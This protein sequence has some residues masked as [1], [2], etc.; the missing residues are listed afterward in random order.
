MGPT[1]WRLP[2]TVTGPGALQG[3]HLIAM[4]LAGQVEP[5]KAGDN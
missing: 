3:H 4:G 2:A 1:P 5:P